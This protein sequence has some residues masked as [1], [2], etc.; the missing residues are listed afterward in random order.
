MCVNMCIYALNLLLYDTYTM[1][2]YV[3][4]CTHPSLFLQDDKVWFSSEAKAKIK[5]DK[6]T[7]ITNLGSKDIPSNLG[8]YINNTV[9]RNNGYSIMIRRSQAV[10]CGF[11]R[12]IKCVRDR[13]ASDGLSSQVIR[14]WGG[15]TTDFPRAFCYKSR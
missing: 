4:V 3:H 8:P 12:G 2:Q 9:A 14:F 10:K 1:C 11:R 5:A 13:T 6:V 7:N 15:S